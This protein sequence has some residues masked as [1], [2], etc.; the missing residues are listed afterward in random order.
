MSTEL[1]IGLKSE[2]KRQVGIKNWK[3][4]IIDMDRK[5]LIKSWL[6]LSDTLGSSSVAEAIIWEYVRDRFLRG[7]GLYKKLKSEEI[8]V[9]THIGDYTNKKGEVIKVHYSESNNYIGTVKK[10]GDKPVSYTGWF[11]IKPDRF[12]INFCQSELY[13]DCSDVERLF[14]PK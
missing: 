9:F 4:K 13:N 10:L 8:G 1:I 11:A 5:Y 7:D 14:V 3:D 2:V 6:K 12:K